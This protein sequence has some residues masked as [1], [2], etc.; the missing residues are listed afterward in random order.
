M[1]LGQPLNPVTLQKCLYKKVDGE[2]GETAELVKGL[3][4]KLRDQVQA[5]KPHQK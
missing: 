3:L 1:N 5:S 4:C 2:P